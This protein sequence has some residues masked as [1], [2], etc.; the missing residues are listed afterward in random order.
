MK[1]ADH[2][3]KEQIRR[4]NQLRRQPKKEREIITKRKTVEILTERDWLDIMGTN[5]N[6]YKRVYEAVRRR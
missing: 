2:L 6:T 1:F 3:N 4:F 5:R